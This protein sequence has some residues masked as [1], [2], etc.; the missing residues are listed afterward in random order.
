MNIT[1]TKHHKQARVFPF[2]RLMDT[3]I[4][5]SVATFRVFS[6]NQ[7]SGSRA[8][9]GQIDPPN[10][11]DRMAATPVTEGPL[12]LSKLAS[13][14]VTYL[15]VND[16]TRAIM[17]RSRIWRV[18]SHE[19]VIPAT[20]STYWLVTLHGSQRTI[21]R[22][23][24]ML[25]ALCKYEVS[26][27]EPIMDLEENSE[28]DD[29]LVSDNDD[30]IRNREFGSVSPRRGHNEHV[31]DARQTISRGKMS[32]ML[33]GS[34]TPWSSSH[35]SQAMK[36]QN[37]QASKGS[38]HERY[39]NALNEDSNHQLDP[40]LSLY[41]PEKKDTP[42]SSIN[43]HPPLHHLS[44]DN[45]T[46]E[47]SNIGLESLGDTDL[48]ITSSPPLTPP[49]NGGEVDSLPTISETE[50]QSLGVPISPGRSSNDFFNITDKA[51]P[52]TNQSSPIYVKTEFTKEAPN[53]S[54]V[55]Y[56][57]KTTY[58]DTEPRMNSTNEQRDSVSESESVVDFS[59]DPPES[60]SEEAFSTEDTEI[61]STEA[62]KKY[63][64]PTDIQMR[65]KFAPRFSHPLIPASHISKF[66]PTRPAVNSQNQIRPITSLPRRDLTTIGPSNLHQDVTT[67]GGY[68]GLRAVK[69]FLRKT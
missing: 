44:V 38:I 32:Q 13:N 65:D 9:Y 67:V 20:F 36:Q 43:E 35:S 16:F 12:L 33:N 19:L 2:H 47:Q 25:S 10:S 69:G 15:Q 41:T 68:I 7:A 66:Y 4:T 14:E 27:D 18:S 55:T 51:V 31:R 23:E 40:P 58:I 30:D 5:A 42:N 49:S 3:G 56:T 52:A 8:G 54:V 63:P 22:L 29:L 34:E 21:A 61:S 57:T 45:G 39:I 26:C 50:V 1:Q 64:H 6:S 48:S 62:Y 11:K 24:K 59:D 28:D 46:A 37:R 53:P 17:A 60:Y